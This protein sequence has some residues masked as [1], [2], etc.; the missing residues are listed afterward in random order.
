MQTHIVGPL[1]SGNFLSKKLQ[2]KYIKRH[3]KTKESKME[4][5]LKC[6]D[7]CRR[8]ILVTGGKVLDYFEEI[9]L[10]PL[11]TSKEI[12]YIPSFARLMS[13]EENEK[14]KGFVERFL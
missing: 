11:C 10:S 9:E 2:K 14:V 6:R 4:K 12:P 13:G 3:C 1:W 7:E 8:G 5:M